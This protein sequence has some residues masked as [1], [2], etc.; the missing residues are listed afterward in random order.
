MSYQGL[1]GK[2]L[3]S[4]FVH[5]TVKTVFSRALSAKCALFI[6]PSRASFCYSNLVSAGVFDYRL[7]MKSLEVQLVR[8]E[9]VEQ[10]RVGS[11]NTA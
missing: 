1:G 7:G 3:S 9:T 4:L 5:S 8:V 6:S 2:W 11:T 10:V